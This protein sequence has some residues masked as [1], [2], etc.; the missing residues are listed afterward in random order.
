MMTLEIEN[1]HAG[2]G[3]SLVLN[4]IDMEV[5]EGQVACIIG[6]NG[7]GKSTLFRCIFNLLGASKGSIAY[8]G[9]D[10]ADWSQQKLLEMGMVYVLQRD[11]VFP[12]MTVEENIE[13]GAFIAESDYD[14]KGH[15]Q[16]VY[17]MFPRLEERKR[18]K[19]GTLSGGERQML[20]F[21]RGLMLDPKLLLID[22]PTAGLSPEYLEIIFEKIQEINTKGV[23][24]L[25]IEQNIKTGLKFSDY[26][27]VLEN[28]RM[29]YEGVPDTLLDQPEIREAYLG[30]K[31]SRDRSGR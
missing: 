20:E 6:P 10:I 13:L 14:L 5:E 16:E 29:V 12:D 17:G 19:A 24:I 7:A 9:T 2:Y 25:M 1:L 15:L 28:G 22:E 18:Q 21:A 26:G 11:A 23:T 31:S 4:G 8:E 3:Q 30:G 27:F